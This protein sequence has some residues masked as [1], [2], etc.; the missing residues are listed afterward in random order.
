MFT[1]QVRFKAIECLVVIT[2]VGGSSAQAQ[3]GP[4]LF[5]QATG[6]EFVQM[7]RAVL[8]GS[9]MGPSDGWFKPAETRYD[10]GWLIERFDANNDAQIEPAE[11]GEHTQLFAL[12]DRD[13]NGAVRADDFDWSSRSPYLRQLSDARR[14]MGPADGDGDGQLSSAEWQKLFERAAGDD[15]TLTP[16]DVRR[17]LN[18]QAQPAPPRSATQGPSKETLLT[19]LFN[20]ELG[21]PASGPEVGDVAPNFTLPTQ[22]GT[23]AITL[24]EFRGSKPVVLI[25]GSFT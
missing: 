19:G 22:D 5:D 12:L 21:S 18:P 9:Q 8:S 3:P 14:W 20:G 15:G 13:G 2:L 11:Y 6:S 10:W 23:R 17:L 24:W 4:A 16:E 1:R 25:F 7:F